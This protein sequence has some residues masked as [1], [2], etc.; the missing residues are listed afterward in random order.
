MAVTS[1]ANPWGSRGQGSLGLRPARAATVADEELDSSDLEEV[2]LDIYQDTSDT[3]SDISDIL[4]KAI[5]NAGF[6]SLRQERGKARD[7]EQKGFDAPDGDDGD[8]K[9]ADEPKLES[10]YASLLSDSDDEALRI[11]LSCGDENGFGESL[12]AHCGRALDDWLPDNTRQRSERPPN[13]ANVAATRQPPV[14]A[15]ATA[16]KA[17]PLQRR[18][19]EGNARR[20]KVDAT[21]SRLAAGLPCGPGAGDT[22]RPRLIS[23]TS[24]TSDDTG[25]GSDAPRPMPPPNARP[26]SARSYRPQRPRSATASSILLRPRSA[27]Q[28]YSVSAQISHRIGSHELP[29][30]SGPL[31]PHTPPRPISAANADTMRSTHSL[32][33][34]VLRRS[35]SHHRSDDRTQETTDRAVSTSKR[36]SETG[37]AAS[38]S[39]PSSASAKRPRSASLQRPSSASMHGASPSTYQHSVQSHSSLVRPTSASSERPRPPL[40]RPLSAS[41]FRVPTGRESVDDA[42][43][44]TLVVARKAVHSD[45]AVWAA[46]IPRPSSRF[47][48]WTNPVDSGCKEIARPVEW[49]RV[50]DEI[51]LEILRRLS[52]L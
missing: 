6:H 8:S 15:G 29:H 1:S 37:A 36:D 17:R 32:N 14:R 52:L 9:L 38:L 40:V 33:A 41:G 3:D 26:A 45:Q 11:C 24:C 12:C 49:Q 28:A 25:S 46:S 47:N 44:T 20:K 39:R 22:T 30:E 19:S 27:S 4:V 35:L 5:E 42:L 31:L 16:T 21:F 23:L 18:R 34:S 48:M 2:D 50:P 10:I 7:C 13:Q 43:Q 51:V